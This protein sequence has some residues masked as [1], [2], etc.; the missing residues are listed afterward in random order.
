MG[1]ALDRVVVVGDDGPFVADAQ[2][3]ATA[4]LGLAGVWAC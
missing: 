4:G 3:D 2:V 1:D